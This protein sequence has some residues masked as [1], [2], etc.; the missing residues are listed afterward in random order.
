MATNPYFNVRSLEDISRITEYLKQSG[1]YDNYSS[2]QHK[3]AI[4][5]VNHENLLNRQETQRRDFLDSFRH[6]IKSTVPAADNISSTVRR[7]RV[8]DLRERLTE[9]SSVKHP[10]IST[11]DTNSSNRQSAPST[12]DPQNIAH[13]SIPLSNS[14]NSYSHDSP[15]IPILDHDASNADRN[16]NDKIYQLYGN[17]LLYNKGV[18]YRHKLFSLW[19]VK[20]IRATKFSVEGT[21]YRLHPEP[22]IFTSN[23]SSSLDN[24]YIL[25]QEVF[26]FIFDGFDDSYMARFVV[27]SPYLEQPITIKYQEYYK[28]TP[29]L[30]VVE[31]E[32]VT[33]SRTLFKL[34]ET[35]RLHVITCKLR[36]GG[37]KIKYK[38]AENLVFN[39]RSIKKVCKGMKDTFCLSKSIVIGRALADFPESTHT[40]RKQYLAES[41]HKQIFAEQEQLH[42][43][44]GIPMQNRLY[45]VG[46]DCSQFQK[47]LLPQYG[48]YIFDDML[49]NEIIFRPPQILPGMKFIYLLL[50]QQ[51]FHTISNIDHFMPKNRAFCPVCGVRYTTNLSKLH[52]DCKGL[53]NMCYHSRCK[54]ER[55][56]SNDETKYCSDCYRTFRN[57]I[58]YDLHKKVAPGKKAPACNLFHKCPQCHFIVQGT[59]ENSYH[60][61][62]GESF[63]RVCKRKFRIGSRHECLIRKVKG[64]SEYSSAESSDDS[65]YESTTAEAISRI[66][67]KTIAQLVKSDQYVE[68]KIKICSMKHFYY[69]IETTIVNN[70]H[71]PVLVVLSDD[72]GNNKI[73]YGTDCIDRFCADVFSTDYSN[74]IFISHGGK[75]FDHMFLL[76]YAHK[77]SLL[78]DVILNGCQILQMKYFPLNIVFRDNLLFVGTALSELP[79]MFDLTKEF[80]QIDKTFFPYLVPFQPNTDAHIPLPEKSKFCYNT[81]KADRREAFDKWYED[82]KVSEKP[83]YYAKNLIEYCERDVEILRLS[84]NKFR[85]IMLKLSSIDP[86]FECLTLSQLSNMSFR[87]RFMPSRS[88]GVIGRDRIIMPGKNYSI[89]SITWLEYEMV[90]KPGLFI[91]HALRGGEQRIEGVFCDGFSS[92]PPGYKGICWMFSGCHFHQCPIHNDLEKFNT[93]LNMHNRDIYERHLATLAKLTSAGYLVQHLWEHQ[94]VDMLR[95]DPKL[96]HFAESLDIAPPLRVEQALYGGRV[97]TWA[98]IRETYGAEE[99]KYSDYSSLYPSIL[100]ENEFPIGQPKIFLNCDVKDFARY[101]GIVHCTILPNPKLR[102]AVLPFRAP[103]GAIFYTLCRT[104]CLEKQK[105]ACYH[106]VEERCLK[107]VWPT[108]E[109]HLSLKY[110][111]Q[112]IAIHEVYHFE[113]HKRSKLIFRDY[114]KLFYSL[115][116]YIIFRAI[117]QGY[118]LLF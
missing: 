105:T 57:D 41:N 42:K 21:D 53:C 94:Y 61:S 113:P 111:Y 11:H 89:M 55:Y 101:Y 5:K 60:H 116:I 1:S 15:R 110:G 37:G 63:C 35:L 26:N 83:F 70:Y 114:V 32:K 44:A 7:Q 62:C 86:Y 30:V 104:C 27:M 78:F 76:E 77:K 81:M 88:L 51:H 84:C 107:G 31:L 39:K 25:F 23:I 18:V 98:L 93:H 17:Q 28:I 50:K 40:K 91:Q 45:T 36:N 87:K 34:D 85:K 33:R 71:Q 16:R 2:R 58:C 38:C 117:F 90:Q 72:S 75:I 73:Y 100:A 80:G 118:C 66:P 79:K 48:I 68:N 65:D 102:I 54:L 49:R 59:P 13:L 22:E 106:E 4:L 8:S 6:S 97:E 56:S 108:P 12:S 52:S 47:C 3:L 115:K 74:S 82:F 24:I 109:V 64:T 95:C 9:I 92:G 69:D 10:R 96:K 19:E 103:D 46:E 67:P 43:K 14:D 112:L 99:I 20:R 29:E